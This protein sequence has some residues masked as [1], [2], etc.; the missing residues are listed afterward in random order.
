MDNDPLR[1]DVWIE[2]ALR[3][4]IERALALAADEGLPGDHHFYITF[5][6]GADGVDV[7]SYLRAEHPDEMTIVLQH[8]YES[9]LVEHDRFAVTLRFK[10][11][12]EQLVIPYSAITSFADPSVNFGLQL[13]TVSLDEDE[14]A[15][16]A[17]DETDEMAEALEELP[18]AEDN[19]D[20]ENDGAQKTGEVIALDAF[21]NKTR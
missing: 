4:V 3:R 7:P 12:P 10:G 8:Q 14:L 15:A 5:K 13:K 2:E 16:I 19:D 20:L 6:T 21:R 9:L 17:S 1:Y 11:K 18:T